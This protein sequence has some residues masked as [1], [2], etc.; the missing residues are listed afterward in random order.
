MLVSPTRRGR[1][2]G[3]DDA[4]ER[5]VMRILNLGC[6]TKLSSSPDVT[7][8]DWSPYLL[9]KQN[10]VLRRVAPLLL[11]P[12]RRRRFA[13]MGDNVLRHDLAKG[14]PAASG[15]IDAVYHS[16]LL[17][18]LDRDVAPQFLLEVKRVLKPGGIHRI[19]V[20]DFERLCS[21]YLTHVGAC[22]R[23]PSNV[24]EAQAHDGYIG[25]VIEQSVRRGA[26]AS[27][28]HPRTRRMVE[29]FLIGDA[30]RRGE[31]HQ[32]MYDRI[33]L[34]ALLTQLG[35]REPRLQTYA[36]SS[37]PGWPRYGLDTDDAGQEYKPGSLYLEATT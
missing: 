14:I 20:P 32:W 4:Q 34:A 17:E 30:R 26:F 31:T 11:D 23:D 2:G 29:D 7:N 25:A 27:R 36:S 19:V 37:I 12:P 1:S 8:I 6:G 5:G 22:D 10:A 18:H 28:Q 15:T 16:H 9:L 33:S 13:A 21:E 3:E 24:A 35:Y